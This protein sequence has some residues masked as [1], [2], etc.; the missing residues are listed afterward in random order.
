MK[1]KVFV[2]GSFL[3]YASIDK[4]Q[5]PEPGDEIFGVHDIKYIVCTVLGED[6]DGSIVVG[7]KV[8]KPTI[9]VSQT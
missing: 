5:Y 1:L 4:P 9:G 3:G 2:G 6:A 8:V 7:A